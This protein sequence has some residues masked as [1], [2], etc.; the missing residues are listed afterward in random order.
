MVNY[1]SLG[2]YKN[3]TKS[4]GGRIP[5]Q[6]ERLREGLWL[7]LKSNPVDLHSVLKAGTEWRKPWETTS[8]IQGWQ[9]RGEHTLHIPCAPLWFWK[10]ILDNSG[11]QAA[12][13][14]THHQAG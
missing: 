7:P 6:S 13:G 5:G 4:S 3:Q 2:T 8:Q 1:V 9:R 14:L 11:Y 12:F 10:M